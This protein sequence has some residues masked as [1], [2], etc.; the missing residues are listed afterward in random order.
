M[1]SSEGHDNRVQ[2]GAARR[3]ASPPT[4][5]V[6]MGVCGSFTG[7]IL[8]PLEQTGDNLDPRTYAMAPREGR[9]RNSGPSTDELVTSVVEGIQEVKGQKICLVDF[10]TL[11][12]SVAARFVICEAQSNTQVEAIARSVEEFTEKQH[13][14]SP[15]TKQGL[16]SGQWALLDYA[17]VVV[18]V[19]HK[20]WRGH[21]GLE[22]LWADA[23]QTHLPDLEDRGPDPEDY[24]EY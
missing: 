20:D 17:D 4:E 21:Y 16:R 11:P 10:S 5:S 6:Q 1:L 3:W 23:E 19:F 12:N 7:A 14:E 2:G 8:A 15:W 9:E 24:P 22:E 13:D 18:H